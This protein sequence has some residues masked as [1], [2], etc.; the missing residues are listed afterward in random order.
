[1]R[2]D[3]FCNFFLRFWAATAAPISRVNYAEMAGDSPKQYAQ[4][5]CSIKCRFQ[6]S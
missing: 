4:E 5:I 6:Q 2:C 3:E 1:M